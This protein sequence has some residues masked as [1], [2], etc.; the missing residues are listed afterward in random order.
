MQ[1]PSLVSTQSFYKVPERGKGLHGEAVQWKN[2]QIRS[3]RF[4]IVRVYVSHFTGEPIP[5]EPIDHEDGWVDNCPAANC[6]C[7]PLGAH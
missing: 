1:T 3:R 6:R 7:L 2:H 5:L 4:I